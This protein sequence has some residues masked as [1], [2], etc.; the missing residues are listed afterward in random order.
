MLRERI[1]EEVRKMAKLLVFPHVMHVG[2]I[3]KTDRGEIYG[4]SGLF[5]QLCSAGRLS[6]WLHELNL[7]CA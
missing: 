3:A 7:Y 5:Q 6:D 2:A 4:D 1:A